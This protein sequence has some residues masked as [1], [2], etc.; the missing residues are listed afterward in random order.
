[1]PNSGIRW[2]SYDERDRVQSWFVNLPMHKLMAFITNWKRDTGWSTAALSKE[3]ASHI[4]TL[5]VLRVHRTSKFVQKVSVALRWYKCVG[6]WVLICLSGRILFS[7]TTHDFVYKKYLA[8]RCGSQAFTLEIFN[9][10]YGCGENYGTYFFSSDLRWISRF[11][12][13]HVNLVTV[14]GTWRAYSRVEHHILLP[15]RRRRY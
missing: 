4:S 2:W 7:G 9:V 13:G 10:S 14:S 15:M 5:R 3:W 12:T 1:M 6:Y 8:P 11:C